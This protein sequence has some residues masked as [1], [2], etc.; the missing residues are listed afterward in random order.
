VR[1]P[2]AAAIYRVVGTRRFRGH[3]PGTEFSARLE[4]LAVNRAIRRGAIELVEKIEPC[5]RRGSYTLPDGW[6]RS[7]NGAARRLTTIGG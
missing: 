7:G 1:R 6:A 3:E 2:P 5:L 4:P